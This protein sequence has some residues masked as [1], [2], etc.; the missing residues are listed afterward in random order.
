MSPPPE[1]YLVG[2]LVLIVLYR[3]MYCVAILISNM[4]APLLA[5]G[6]ALNNGPARTPPMGWNPYN[7][8]NGNYNETIVIYS[9]LQ[10]RKGRF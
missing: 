4:L 5:G 8:F 2:G 6:L 1:N 3:Y 9:H 10:N 7:H